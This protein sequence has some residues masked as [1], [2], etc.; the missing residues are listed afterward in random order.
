MQSLFPSGNLLND[1]LA[2]M[3]CFM[4]AKSPVLAQNTFP[5]C[6]EWGVERLKS[7]WENK[8]PRLLPS[9]IRT[10]PHNFLVRLD[11]QFQSGANQPIVQIHNKMRRR[12]SFNVNANLELEKLVTLSYLGL[13]RGAYANIVMADT[14]HILSITSLLITRISQPPLWVL[15]SENSLRLWWS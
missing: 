5:H 8:H 4:I 14:D 2:Q 9:S 12:I 15:T 11:L 6:R 13:F 7:I 1:S 3:N 10:L